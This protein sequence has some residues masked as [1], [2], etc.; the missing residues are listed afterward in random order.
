MII[1]LALLIF[2]HASAAVDAETRCGLNWLDANANCHSLCKNNGDCPKTAP[3][4]YTGL[5]ETCDAT[6]GRLKTMLNN[7]TT[8]AGLNETVGSGDCGVGPASL[9]KLPLAP[10]KQ[11]PPDNANFVK[12]RCGANTTHA[13][14]NCFRWCTSDADCLPL[15]A[16]F[17]CQ[18]N[19]PTPCANENC[20]I[21]VNEVPLQNPLKSRCGMTFQ[22]AD[23]NCHEYCDYPSDCPNKAHQCFSGLHKMCYTQVGQQCGSNS[24]KPS[25]RQAPCDPTGTETLLCNSGV[26]RV[27]DV[28]VLGGPCAGKSTNPPIC[29]NW[30]TCVP[31]IV[32][33]DN[34]GT[35]QIP[36]KSYWG[37]KYQ[38]DLSGGLMTNCQ[39]KLMLRMS[40]LLETGNPNLHG[41]GACNSTDDAQGISAGFI[42]FT[43]CAG[44]VRNVCNTFLDLHP[45]N[46]CSKYM[47][48]LNSEFNATHCHIKPATGFYLLDFNQ[49]FCKDWASEADNP[50]FQEA[51]LMEQHNNYFSM[52]SV[53]VAETGV[54]FPLTIAEIQD[55]CI[56][57]GD[58]QP[59][60]DL[61]EQNGVSSPING[62]DEYTWLGAFLDARKQI[63]LQMGG[64]Y[65]KSVSRIDLVKEVWKANNVW[66]QND[67]LVIS[68][69]TLSCKD[70]F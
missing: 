62:G 7:G 34:E 23:N 48:T 16:N 41:F 36:Y 6:A 70:A 42:Q 18:A 65:A 57:I 68:N 61:V 46:F 9:F 35:C 30:L 8:V 29:D 56:Q 27:A 45:N 60:V 12:S 14:A 64:S 22:D 10:T 1:T 15:D 5:D 55:A 13:N 3:T 4:C 47:D 53:Y 26:C 32:F 31:N 40:S 37:D 63:Q 69:Q 43:T 59:I 20:P 38:T 21:R 50:M 19:L 25:E 51:Q 54:R 49:T 33:P 28:S 11:L 52:T 17:A 39:Y 44:T 67:T 58:V 2:I 24:T 66:F